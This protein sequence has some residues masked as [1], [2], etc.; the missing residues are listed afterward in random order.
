MHQT[1]LS[2]CG[3]PL[4]MRKRWAVECSRVVKIVRRCMTEKEAS[5]NTFLRAAALSMVLLS[6][7]G[8]KLLAQGTDPVVGTWELNVVKSKYSPGPA[9]KSEMRTYVVAGQD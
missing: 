6:L 9:P 8:L 2:K 1:A 7:S 4:V 3:A 5:M